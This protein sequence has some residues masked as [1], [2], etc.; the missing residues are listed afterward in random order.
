VPDS[1]VASGNREPSG[2]TSLRVRNI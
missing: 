2:R 1:G